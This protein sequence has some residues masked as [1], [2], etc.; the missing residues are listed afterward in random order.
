M[1]S[2]HIV[3][4]WDHRYDTLSELTEPRKAAT[5]STSEGGALIRAYTKS[6]S[7]ESSF[8]TFSK[9]AIAEV[10]KLSG[11]RSSWSIYRGKDGY[12]YLHLTPKPKRTR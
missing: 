1:E 4:L 9:M 10:E 12:M 7:A 6:P 11:Y 5:A 2:E 8:R 3:L